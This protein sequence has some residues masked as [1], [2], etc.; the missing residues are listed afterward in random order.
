[1]AAVPVAG[2]AVFLVRDRPGPAITGAAETHVQ[3]L[4]ILIAAPESLGREE[5]H[6]FGQ[7]V[8]EH[9]IFIA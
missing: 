9:L 1:V 5:N 6:V 4:G 2:V 7:F 8:D 3:Q